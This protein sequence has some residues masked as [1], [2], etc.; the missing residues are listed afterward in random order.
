MGVGGQSLLPK[1]KLFHVGDGGIR[2]V[3]T[4]LRMV[5]LVI[6]RKWMD[7]ERC[8]QWIGSRDMGSICGVTRRVCP[9]SGKWLLRMWIEVG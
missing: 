3:R 6:V 2:Q 9:R 5:R 1:D 7:L 8:F 4:Q